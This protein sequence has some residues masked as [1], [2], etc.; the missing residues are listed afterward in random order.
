MKYSVLTRKLHKPELPGSFIVRHDL[1]SDSG[2][3]SVILVS[4][5]AGSGKSMA[6]S[7]WLSEQ[8]RAYAWYSLD[9][10]DNDPMQFLA[11]LVSAIR[12]F[13]ETVYGTLDQMLDAFSSVGFDSFLRA[14]IQQL[15][16][17]AAPFL[18]ALD[19]YHLIRSEQVHRIVKTLLEHFPPAM[20]LVIITR[21]DPPL[22][23]ARIRAS[24]KLF[25]L[26]IAD[27]RFTDEQVKAFF[28]MQPGIALDGEQL[29]QL[30]RRTE[31]WIAGLQMAAL[32][33]RGSADVAGFVNTFSASHYYIMDYLLEEVLERHTPETRA[34]FLSTSILDS[35]SAGLCDDMLGLPPG[36]SRAVIE[37]LVKT[38]SFII[39]LDSQHQWYRYHHLFRDILRQRLERQPVRETESC[40]LRAGLWLREHGRDQEAVHHLLKANA[41]EAAAGLIECRWAE[42]DMQAQSSLWLDMAKQLP[43][44]CIGKSPVLAM[45]YGW[46]L[47][48]KG[49]I[50]AC[51]PW[52]VR[53]RR[54]YDRYREDPRREECIVADTAQFELLPA[55]IASAYAYIAAA[56]GDIEGTFRYTREALAL[57]PADQYTKRGIVTVLLGIAHWRNGDM[58]KAV[59]VLSDSLKQILNYVNPFFENSYKLMLGELYIQQG[60]PGKAKTV[61]LETI[62]KVLERGEAPLILA[63]LYL[64]LA[65]V[66]FL[67]NENGE[68]Y[69]L[70]EESKAHGQRYAL[71][72]W[73]Y[74]Y[75][76]L[77]ARIYGREGLFG[78]ARDCIAEGRVN[79][80]V[81]PIPDDFTLE[82]AERMVEAAENE[83]RRNPPPG[84]ADADRTGFARERANQALAEPLTVR[85]LEV[86]ELI[87]AGYSNEEICNKLFLA[88]S[89][90]KS[91]NQ[92]IFGKLQANRRTQAAAR[93]RE[94]GL[95]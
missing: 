7:A 18:L 9:E 56:T 88:L 26:R 55:T 12:A 77:L 76:L 68:A 31:G 10:W 84:A 73:R 39:P 61:F 94:L 82:D 6:V 14:L 67:Q 38:N 42:M 16:T 57:L 79:Y 27:L 89:T 22:P 75:N 46:A 93:A 81:N 35:F 72:D 13:D 4:A 78:L 45:G 2:W 49:E 40:H 29:Q 83:G 28:Q 37:T 53:A 1:L 17:I 85:E 95:V 24:N 62:A 70:L 48:D 59:E 11:Y 64:G 23:L 87:A 80:Y 20:Q 43:T 30:A 58:Q 33:M 51:K 92:H 41:V 69:A 15:H 19:D 74:K 90:V 8:D 36:E 63:S 54:L 47:L 25:E 44:E 65:K 34:F 66:A 3:A 50:E 60:T 5:Q 21:E 86:L 71:M 52:L 91:Y 32:S